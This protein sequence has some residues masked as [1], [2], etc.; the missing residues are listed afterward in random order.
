MKP[1]GHGVLSHFRRM[2]VHRI[3]QN[4]LALQACEVARSLADRDNALMISTANYFGERWR[5]S[6]APDSRTFCGLKAWWNA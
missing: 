1:E 6:S 3:A 2:R 5:M 4:P